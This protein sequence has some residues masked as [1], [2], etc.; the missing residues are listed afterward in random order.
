M[1]SAPTTQHG[2]LTPV[3]Y[4]RRKICNIGFIYFFCKS[5]VINQYLLIDL[6]LQND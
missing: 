6:Y 4:L 5:K 3:A 2:F 1:V